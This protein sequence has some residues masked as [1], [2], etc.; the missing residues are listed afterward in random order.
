MIVLENVSK[1]FTTKNGVVDAVKNV[2]LH[3]KKGEI[4]GVIGH[5]GAGKSSPI[6]SDNK[7]ERPTSGQIYI[8]GEEKTSFS[9][10]KLPEARQN[11]G[12]IFQC[13][14]LLKTAT[15]YDN[16]AIPLKLLSLTKKKVK[17]RV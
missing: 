3:V 5:S 4:H 9:L 6:P 8:N 12:M 15:V 17:D 2:N 14:N 11:I 1:S 7:L 16:I 13:F 10:P